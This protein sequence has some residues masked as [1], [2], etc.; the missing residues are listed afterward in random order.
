MFSGVFVCW[1]EVRGGGGAVDIPAAPHSG[2]AGSF[3]RVVAACLRG[4]WQCASQRLRCRFEVI[5]WGAAGTPFG[6]AATYTD[7][8]SHAT[9]TYAFA[10]QIKDF[11]SRTHTHAL[12]HTHARTHAHHILSQARG[13]RVCRAPPCHAGQSALQRRKNDPRPL[14]IFFPAPAVAAAEPRAAD[15]A[16]GAAATACNGLRSLPRPAV[17]D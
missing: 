7:T 2:A 5:P 15:A 1:C 9:H 11:H 17:G 4:V 10:H 6:T 12:S 13:C 16:A 3:A 8:L 14:Q